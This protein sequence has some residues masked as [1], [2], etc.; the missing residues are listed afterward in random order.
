MTDAAY[1]CFNQ[2]VNN[3]KY[4]MTRIKLNLSESQVFWSTYNVAVGLK[5]HRESEQRN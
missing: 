3:I 5:L 4:L 2:H 1:S